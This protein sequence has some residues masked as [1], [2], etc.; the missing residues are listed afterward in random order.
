[1]LQNYLQLVER[2]ARSSGLSVEDIERRIEA[3]RAKLSGLISK[4]GAAQVV[5]SELGISF[6]KEKMKVSEL[7]SGM[8]RANVIGKIIE[9]FPIRSYEKNDRRGKIC[10]FV[11]ADET[12]NIRTVL[13]DTNHIALF[14]QEKIKQGDVIEI[15]NA[16]IRNNELHLTG[17][18]DIKLSNEIMKEVKTEK[19]FHEKNIAELKQEENIGIRAFIVQ[20]FEPRF[21]NICPACGKGVGETNECKEHGKVVGEKRALLSL[22]LDDGTETIRA[23][24]FSE[25]IAKIIGNIEEISGEFFLKK[26]QEMLGREMSFSGQA[27]QSKIFDNLEFFVSDAGE[28]DVDKLIEKLEKG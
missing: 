28:V 24:L 6:E 3:K 22:V 19:I 1:M 14:E 5:A 9:M 10:S 8:K 11:L 16:S 18:S 25:Q 7:L 20:V 13:W 21:F 15:T 26:R 4:E 23:V 17:F 2:I 12:S 27:R